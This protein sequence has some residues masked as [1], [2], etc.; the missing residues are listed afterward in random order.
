VRL[1]AVVD[2]SGGTAHLVTA[3][4]AAL[5]GAALLL[6]VLRRNRPRGR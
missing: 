1:E 6:Q 3:A 5:A 2:A 4:A